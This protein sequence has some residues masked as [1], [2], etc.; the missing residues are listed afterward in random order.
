[1]I[2]WQE[3]ISHRLLPRVMR[4]LSTCTASAAPAA[5]PHLELGLTTQKM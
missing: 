1:M 4:G 3:F 5:K 2:H